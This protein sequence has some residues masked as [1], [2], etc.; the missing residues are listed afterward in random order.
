MTRTSGSRGP[1][2]TGLG[3]CDARVLQGECVSQQGR[4]VVSYLRPARAPTTSDQQDGRHVLAE[5]VHHPLEPERPADWRLSRLARAGARRPAKA[6]RRRRS[7]SSGLQMSTAA[8]A[9][10]RTR[11]H[12]TMQRQ[13]KEGRVRALFT[14]TAIVR[15]AP[16]ARDTMGGRMIGAPRKACRTRRIALS[17]RGVLAWM[18]W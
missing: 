14:D 11:A 2:P 12:V 13:T 7:P 9:R 8:G 16:A 17:I 3:G 4:G 10:A 6:S 18:A 15:A 5:R 1:R